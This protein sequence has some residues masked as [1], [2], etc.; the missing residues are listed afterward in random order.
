MQLIK[1][2]RFANKLRLLV[3]LGALATLV[4]GAVGVSRMGMLNDAAQELYGN[5]VLGIEHL[6][7]LKGE[8]LRLGTGTLNQVIDSGYPKVVERHAVS[9]RAAKERAGAAL[10]A[11]ESTFEAGEDT[12]GSRDIKQKLQ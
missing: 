5:A 3:L 12:S 8:L 9:V 10:A 2:L 1:N 6:S 11:Y 4:V 7:Q